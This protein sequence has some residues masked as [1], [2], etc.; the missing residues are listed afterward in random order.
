MTEIVLS[1]PGKNALDRDLMERTHA[2][3]E[4]AG[5]SPLLIRGDGDIRESTEPRCDPIDP[6]TRPD[7]G[8][9]EVS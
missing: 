5:D 4:A 9:D 1:G 2:A 7:L 6:F 8:F 3:I